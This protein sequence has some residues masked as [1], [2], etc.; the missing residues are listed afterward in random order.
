[1][2]AFVLRRGVARDPVARLSLL[3]A[4][5]EPIADEDPLV[6]ENS[7]RF[8]RPIIRRKE[9]SAPKEEAEEKNSVVDACDLLGAIIPEQTK[10][11]AP[12]RLFAV[13]GG[14]FNTTE[15]FE[16]YKART[17]NHMSLE[18]KERLGI[19]VEKPA[20]EEEPSKRKV[21]AETQEVKNDVDK[22]ERHAPNDNFEPP[23]LFKKPELEH[24]IRH[25]ESCRKEASGASHV[26]QG[27]KSVE[28]RFQ[29]SSQ[30][31]QHFKRSTD[32][33]ASS[34]YRR[35]E[36]ARV[37]QGRKPEERYRSH[38]Q[39]P[40]QS[41]N[42]SCDEKLSAA[43]G[44]HDVDRDHATYMRLMNIGRSSHLMSNQRDMLGPDEI[45]SAT[46]NHGHIE[47]SRPVSSDERAVGSSVERPHRNEKQSSN[48]KVSAGFY[49]HKDKVDQVLQ[50]NK[51]VEELHASSTF[52]SSPPDKQ[53]LDGKA[54]MSSRY[55]RHSRYDDEHQ[56]HDRNGNEAGS[57]DNDKRPYL[58]D[59]K[60]HPNHLPKTSESI[61]S[62]NTNSER[63]LR[64]EESE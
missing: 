43:K 4:G 52:K 18:L 12:G 9:E 40:N 23:S 42:K 24:S 57:N 16:K 58:T 51:N 35:Y 50:S 1:M 48:E 3:G 62:T 19:P 60:Y 10:T 33:R 27:D 47:N 25:R 29:P 7:R 34:S 53:N 15:D 38:L 55:E 44:G 26:R 36:E 39:K 13:R 28:G 61:T 56:R 21:I 8:D 41:V 17:T 45:R 22:M 54:P 37:A 59:R 14:R 11:L 5:L 32:E 46:R 20:S 30:E 64:F 31:R 63:R 6:T 49:N 2:D